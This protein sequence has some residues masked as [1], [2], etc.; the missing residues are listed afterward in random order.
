MSTP[1]KSAIDKNS[2]LTLYQPLHD[3]AWHY[4]NMTRM[5]RQETGS[6]AAVEGFVQVLAHL[7]EAIQASASNFGGQPT[8]EFNV[9]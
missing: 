6:R 7:F 1:S 4:R 9:A 8:S 3:F 5:C 2:R